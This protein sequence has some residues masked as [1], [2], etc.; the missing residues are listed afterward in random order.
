V[1][2]STRTGCGRGIQVASDVSDHH[3]ARR[4]DAEASHRRENEPGLRFAAAATGIRQVRAHLPHV[5]RTDQLVDC[6]IHGAELSA[7]DEPPSDAG[8]VRD[9]TNAD[10]RPAQPLHRLDGARHRHDARGIGV[11]GHVDDERAV[12]VEQHGVERHGVERHGVERQRSRRCGAPFG[13]AAFRTV[14]SGTVTLGHEE[15]VPA[16]AAMQTRSHYFFCFSRNSASPPRNCGREMRT[17]D[18]ACVA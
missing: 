5:E 10:T 1:G 14:A 6:G 7:R 17:A 2:T 15:V 9:D 12:P 8:L 18:A 13:E 4:L 3:G 16:G 11:V